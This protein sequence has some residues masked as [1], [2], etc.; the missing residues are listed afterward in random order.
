MCSVFSSWICTSIV[1]SRVVLL[2]RDINFFFKTWNTDWN[3]C[4]MAWLNHSKKTRDDYHLSKMLFVNHP[5]FFKLIPQTRSPNLVRM[6]T[7]IVWLSTR[8]DWPFWNVTG[9]HWFN[10]IVDI[11]HLLKTDANYIFLYLYYST[12]YIKMA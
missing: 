10:H 5:V 12:T 4:W 3:Y 1:C 7:S 9:Q 11:A 2:L 6:V 8:S